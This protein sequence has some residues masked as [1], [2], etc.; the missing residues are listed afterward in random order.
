[1]HGAGDDSLVCT[2][3]GVDGDVGQHVV[4]V[5]RS[6]LALTHADFAGAAGEQFLI[7]PVPGWLLITLTE[8]K[9]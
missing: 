5:L 1:M 4:R 3:L 6:H 2:T 9:S 8:E 7:R